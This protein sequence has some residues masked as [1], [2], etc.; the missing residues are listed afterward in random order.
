M[1]LVAMDGDKIVEPNI[2]SVHEI[3]LVEQAV[4]KDDYQGHI[5][6]MESMIEKVLEIQQKRSAYLNLRLDGLYKELNEN[7]KP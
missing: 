4:K 2:G 6:K 3:S 1:K 5:E 7:L